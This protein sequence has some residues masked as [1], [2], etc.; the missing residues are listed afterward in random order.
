MKTV[1]SAA[2]L[3]LA[4]L[5]ATLALAVTLSGQALERVV[6]VS[7][8]EGGSY[9]P[10]T[11]T[12]AP[13]DVVV[14]EDGVAREVLRVTRATEPMPIAVIVDN[15]APS[16]PAIA[17]LRRALTAFAE[18][19]QGLGP[20][21][22]IS[23]ADRPT[24]LADYT[25]VPASLT[26]A[27]NRVFAVPGSGATLLD[28]IIETARGIG[29]R[30]GERAAIV[31]LVAEHI[32]FSDAHYS[33]V[34]EAVADSGAALHA[35][36]WTRPGGSFGDDRVQNRATVL[37]RGVRESGGLRIDVL[38]S[39]AYESRMRELATVLTHQY[40]VVY[41]RPQTLIPPRRVEVTMARPGLDARATPARGQKGG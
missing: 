28:G 4:A 20:I 18:T 33:Q 29:R 34:L 37:D 2:R 23:V 27:I 8:F 7:V 36:V 21:A 39:Q 31:L 22:L 12:P 6:Y 41:A 3:T 5:A 1:P 26:S 16:S 15:S 24:I 38:A 17:D 10:L 35:V 9:A 14:R 11:E 32:E 19:A 25:T 13:A 30:E 40:R